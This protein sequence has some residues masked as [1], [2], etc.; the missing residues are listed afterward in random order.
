MA[1]SVYDNS[2]ILADKPAGITSSGFLNRVKRAA[3]LKKIGHSG[4]LDKAASG[5][6]V[7]CTGRMTRLC[8]WFL[9]DAKEYT[10]SVKL[11]IATDTCDTEGSIIY[12]KDC[13]G[14]TE[15]EVIRAVKGFEG[16]ILQVPP[17]YSALKVEGRRASDIIRAG[18]SVDLKA[19]RITI[20]AAEVS[21]FDPVN[22]S[23]DIRVACSKGTYIRA[24]VRDIGEVLQTGAHVTGLRRLR[25]G[26]FSIDHAASFDE[27][28]AAS[29]D[30]YPPPGVVLKPALHLSGVM[31]MKV[32][33]A[34]R[35]RVS[36]GAYFTMDEVLSPPDSD[37]GCFVIIDENENLIA[38]A[39][40]DIK[41][42][43]ISYKSVYI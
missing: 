18:G 32:N 11:G 29:S 12:E 3:G 14:I 37:I 36:N 25:S 20:T 40:I 31:P 39:D 19:R 2:V 10:A 7:V 13:S 5:L 30:L 43:H 27:I 24:L 21:N 33:A 17:G 15:A 23:F 34:G 35:E 41:N 26:T 1:G 16:E 8:S 22:K 4:T 38:I 28:A 6:L 42:W 9:D